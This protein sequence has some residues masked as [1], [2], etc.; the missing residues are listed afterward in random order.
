MEK[1]STQYIRAQVLF[2]S[3]YLI[4]NLLFMRLWGAHLTPFLIGMFFGLSVVLGL[5][6]HGFRYLY[7]TYAKNRSLL[8]ISLHLI[9]LIPVAA[10]LAQ[11]IVSG[12]MFLMA[13]FTPKI[14]S[15]AQPVSTGGLLGFTINYCIL[16]GLWCTIYLLRAE[17]QKRRNSEIAH[18]QLQAQLKENELQFLR[19]QINSHF[20]FNA[21][22]N[23]RA[24]VR[25]DAERTRTGLTDLSILL[26]GLLQ[27]DGQQLVT[28]RDELEWVRGYLALE[29]LQFEDRLQFTI[30]V[31]ETLLTAKLPPM[32]LQTLVENAIKH[33]IAARRAGGALQIDIA[34]VND[35]SWQIKVQ[36]PPAE[37][38]TSH[39]G[40][41]IGVRNAR[42][43][44]QLAFGEKAYLDLV[45]GTDI[46]TAKVEMPL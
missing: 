46:V 41:K 20:L 45:I 44:L 14:M 37:F 10:L 18:W 6:S 27:N 4:L 22:N 15:G 5:I 23:L 3:A 33:G 9:W 35:E 30:N 26:R 36:N 43:R 17:F 1:L 2:W 39:Q 11:I 25:E 21:I 40:N 8:N 34:R 19:S 7:K 12:S 28:L 31:D 42:E 38:Q 13:E 32:I 24:M 16:I 29:A